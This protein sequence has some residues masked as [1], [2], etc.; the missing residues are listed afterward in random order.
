MPLVNG[1]AL[2]TGNLRGE[3]H[4]ATVSLILDHSEPGQGPRLHRHP[5]DETWVVIEGNLTFQ[6]GD[7]QLEAGPGAIV[8]VPPDTPHKFINHGPGRSHLVC[9]HASPR[10]VTEWLE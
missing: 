8:I 6:A 2:P 4:G 3:D 9:I 1:N 5:Y 10:F 7:Q